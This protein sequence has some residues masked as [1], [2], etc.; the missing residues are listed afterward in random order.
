MVSPILR[1]GSR[2]DAPARRWLLEWHVCRGEDASRR[3]NARQKS[4]YGKGRAAAK[5][6]VSCTVDRLCASFEA[7]RFAH[8]AEIWTTDAGGETRILNELQHARA[9]SRRPSYLPPRNAGRLRLP[10]PQP[11]A[12]R[13]QVGRLLRPITRGSSPN[14]ARPLHSDTRRSPHCDDSRLLG[15]SGRRHLARGVA[16]G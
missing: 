6:E 10:T 7:R 3:L 14:C 15:R 12:R 1:C 2:P 9:V 16:H 13:A 4:A 8:E 5:R 11:I